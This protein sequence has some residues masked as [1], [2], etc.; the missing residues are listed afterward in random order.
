MLYITR[1]TTEK[2]VVMNE[3]EIRIVKVEDG[4]VQIGITAPPDIPV[5]RFEVFEKIEAAKA[6]EPP[7]KPLSKAATNGTT[8]SG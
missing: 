5:H 7:H 4:R 8:V 1:K 2:I 3:V 6:G